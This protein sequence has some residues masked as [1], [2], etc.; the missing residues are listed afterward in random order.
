[1]CVRAGGVG[2]E[3][4]GGCF[5]A[6]A[7]DAELALHNCKCNVS[8]CCVMLLPLLLP[9]RS[10]CRIVEFRIVFAGPADI[11][12]LACSRM[13]IGEYV[14]MLCLCVLQLENMCV[15]C[16]GT[17][18]GGEYIQCVC[19]FTAYYVTYCL[20]TVVVVVIIVFVFDVHLA[21]C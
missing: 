7:V 20:R 19:M 4:G 6:A 9:L 5:Y 10:V 14:L 11:V 12:Y 3:G 16:Y 18:E 17:R 13:L 8:G 1:M 2:N 15:I 21:S